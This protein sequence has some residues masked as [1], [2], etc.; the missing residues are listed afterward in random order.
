MHEV[1]C[2]YILT[3]FDDDISYTYAHTPPQYFITNFGDALFRKRDIYVLPH[4]VLFIRKNRVPG[5][6]WMAFN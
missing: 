3:G 6:S 2:N 5:P 1:G 4:L